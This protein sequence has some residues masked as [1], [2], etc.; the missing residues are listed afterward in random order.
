VLPGALAAHVLGLAIGSLATASLL[1]L[2]GNLLGHPPPWAVGLIAAGLAPFCLPSLP[3][4]LEGSRWRVPSTWFQAGPAGFAG[5][6]GLTLG[7]GFLTALSSPGFYLVAAWYL[8]VTGTGA[9]VATAALFAIGRALPFLTICLLA[10][11]GGH[12]PL[13][14]VQRGEILVSRLRWVE[15][16]LL[17]VIALWC[18]SD[19]LTG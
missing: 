13:A 11:Y 7:S 6:F 14:L 3:W 15:A 5:L 4:R 8:T 1:H 10:G 18:W 2:V 17:V 16:V 19:R 12:P 9:M